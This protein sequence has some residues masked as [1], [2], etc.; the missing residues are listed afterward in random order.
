MDM[1][2]D[3]NIIR[4]MVVAFPTVGTLGGG[5]PVGLV[6]GDALLRRVGLAAHV[7]SDGVS[8]SCPEMVV[9]LTLEAPHRLTLVRAQVVLAPAAEV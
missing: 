3:K 9:A 4:R 2:R 7:A 5:R 6:A 8:T 1:Y